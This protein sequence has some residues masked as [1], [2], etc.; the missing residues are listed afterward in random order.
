MSHLPPPSVG[1]VLK[2][3]IAINPDLTAPQ[4]I[5]MIR[6]CVETQGVDPLSFEF[7]S[8]ERINEEKVLQ[9]ARASL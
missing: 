6:Q 4:M 5:Q 3:I 9:L 8:A 1:S 7:A 2:K